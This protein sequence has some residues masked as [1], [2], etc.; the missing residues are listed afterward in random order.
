[1]RSGQIGHSVTADLKKGFGPAVTATATPSSTPMSANRNVGETEIDIADEAVDA[2]SPVPVR[3]HKLISVQFIVRDYQLSLSLS[4]SLSPC[5]RTTSATR[6]TCLPIGNGGQDTRVHQ[7]QWNHLF[8]FTGRLRRP[9]TPLTTH[10][11]RWRC[12]P[13]RGGIIKP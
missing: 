1:M 10:K 5:C 2:V 11:C 9:S 6:P 7:W 4:L 13:N 8:A 3:H 12:H